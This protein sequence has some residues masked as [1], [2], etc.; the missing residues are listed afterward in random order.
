MSRQKKT[1]D[2]YLDRS[3]L[4]PTQ[5][6]GVVFLSSL[7]FQVPYSLSARVIILVLLTQHINCFTPSIRNNVKGNLVQQIMSGAPDDVI[8][9]A[10]RRTELLN[11][12]VTGAVRSPLIEGNWLMI[13]T[14]SASIAGKNRP[15]IFQAPKPP[16][17]LIDISRGA[18]LNAETILGVTNAVAVDIA[19]KTRNKVA[20]KFT[21]F[22]LG[23][24]SFAAPAGLTG[25]LETSYLDQT[26]RISR[27]DQGNVFV[28]LRESTERSIADAAWAGWRKGWK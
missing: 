4:V 22:Q 27:G 21:R 23:P 6:K 1:Q 2:L 15:G 11:P 26:M 16:E 24:L 5:G 19:P 17:Q 12:T 20:V 9:S 18:A 7:M 28:L 10:I 3:Y 25:E 8:L 14:T 13:Y